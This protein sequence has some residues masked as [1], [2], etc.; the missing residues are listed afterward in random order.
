[1]FKNLVL[2]IFSI[3]LLSFNCTFAQSLIGGESDRIK[4]KY[5]FLPLPYIN[6]NRAFGA[7]VGA[8]PLFM[9]NLSEKDTISPSSMFGLVG[10]Y[11][12]NK[13][14]FI[15]GFGVL[16]LKEDRWRIK[17]AGGHGD[18]NFQFFAAG[19]IDQWFDYNTSGNFFYSSI[20]RRIASNFY[21]GVG[22]IYSTFETNLENINSGLETDLHGIVFDAALDKRSSVAYPRS[23][24]YIESRLKLYPKFANE[25]NNS[26]QLTFA[27]NHYFSVAQNRDVVATRLYSG[28]SLGSVSF[29]Q[30]FIVGRT[31]IRGY[32]FGEFR[33]ESIVAIQGE[34]RW[35]F[36]E[37]FGA[38][39]FAGLA[40]VFGSN[41]ESDNGRILPGIGTGFR[42][43]FMKDTHSTVGFDVAVGDGDWGF[44]FRLSEAF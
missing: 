12:E 17:V 24:F 32:S 28:L 43:V 29:N 1:M 2:L 20:Q 40:T 4:G 3:T 35:N 6:Y 41:N 31:D 5:K 26:S 11:S 16:Y 25:L 42:Y 37:R 38:V 34:Y 10:I 23:G 36:A 7:S 18:A 13:T 44:Y 27:Y 15:L 39:G 19:P 22:Y 30:Q 9:V 14:W 8:I 21:A 33:G